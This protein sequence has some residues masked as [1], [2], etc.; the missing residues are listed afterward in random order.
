MNIGDRVKMLRVKKGLTQLELAEL[1]GY[2]SKSSVAHIE[3]GRDIPRSMVV[4]LAEALN[5]TP[6][7]LM[8]WSDNAKPEKIGLETIVQLRQRCVRMIPLYES[9]AAGFGAYADSTAVGC[10]PCYIE[11]DWEA[12]NSI[13]VKVKGDSMYP[14]IEDGDIVIICKDMEYEDGKIV[15]ARID[16][17]EAVVKRLRLYPEKLVLESINPEYQGLTFEREDMNRVHI[18][19]VVRTILKKA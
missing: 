2:K 6:T 4:K 5:T 16:D 10:V 13:A 3:N 18:E 14:K 8:G 17:D 9:A 7:F 12:D 11:S 15:V 1:L 19:G